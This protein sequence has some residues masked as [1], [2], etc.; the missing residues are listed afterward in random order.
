MNKNYI[1]VGTY[2]ENS[3]S[4]GFYIYEIDSLTGKLRKKCIGKGINPSYLATIENYI[5][6]VSEIEE[7]GYLLSYQWDDQQGEVIQLSKVELPGGASCHI[8]VW[9]ESN[10]ISVS[11]YAAGVFV[12]C[13]VNN[14]GKITKITDIKENI[15]HGPVVGRQDQAHAHSLTG[16][17]SGNY[18]LGADLGSDTIYIYQ[19]DHTKGVLTPHKLRSQIKL[20]AGEGPRHSVFHPS[21]KFVYVITELNNNIFVYSFDEAKGTLAMCQKYALLPPHYSDISYAADIHISA[22][23]RFLY[24]SVRGYNKIC[25]FAIDEH[26]GLLSHLADQDCYGKWPRNFCITP[27]D[28]HIIIANEKSNNVFVCKRETET[29]L[30]GEQQCEIRLEQPVCVYPFYCK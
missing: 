29:G 22:D 28:K 26:S 4:E 17:R 6:A 14:E 8:N 2:T 21:N 15:G 30:M 16:D 18:F 25:I 7:K 5:F 20:P 13:Q 19:A 23:G 11:N 1:I 3:L 24:A 12:T 10:Y 9:C 27:D